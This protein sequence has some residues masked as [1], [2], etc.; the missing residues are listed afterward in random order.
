MFQFYFKALK[1]ELIKPTLQHHSIREFNY[2][3]IICILF[4]YL[5][6]NHLF[7]VIQCIS[8]H[9]YNSSPPFQCLIN[10]IPELYTGK[11]RTKLQNFVE[12]HSPKPKLLDSQKPTRNMVHVFGSQFTVCWPSWKLIWLLVGRCWFARKLLC[13]IWEFCLKTTIGNQTWHYFD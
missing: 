3:I 4:N 1:N 11:K 12:V 2:F 13:E 5:Y 10:G 9:A 7:F 6:S 8:L